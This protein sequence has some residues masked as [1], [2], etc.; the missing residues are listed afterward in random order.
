MDA[1]QEWAKQRG[2]KGP[3]YVLIQEDGELTGP[4]AKNITDA[5]RAG[6][7]EALARSPAIASSSLLGE[8]KASPHC[9]GA[10]C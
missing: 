3:A 4:V 10:A 1:W 9:Q 8:A 5:E 2:A 7:A 6:L